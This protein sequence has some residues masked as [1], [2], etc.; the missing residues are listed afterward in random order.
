MTL[1]FVLCDFPRRS[2]SSDVKCRRC[3]QAFILRNIS[4]SAS[5]QGPPGLTMEKVISNGICNF[6][7][8]QAG[9]RRLEMRTEIC[10]L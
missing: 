8:V 9:N 7:L 6:C 3:I 1:R 10:V 5:N 4:I 2:V